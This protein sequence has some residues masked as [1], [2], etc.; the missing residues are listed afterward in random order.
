MAP[1][2]YFIGV[3]AVIAACI[4]LKKTK[5]FAGDPSPFV[6]ELPQYHIPDVKTVLMHVWELSLIHISTFSH[7]KSVL[8]KSGFLDVPLRYPPFKNHLKLVKKILK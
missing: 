6:I 2:M 4:I 3:F 1:L 8:Q 5:M 7:E